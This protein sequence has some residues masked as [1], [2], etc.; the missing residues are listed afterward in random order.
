MKRMGW[1]VLDFVLAAIV[2]VLGN[3]VASYLQERFSLTDPVRFTFVA[4]LF[5]VCLG[6]LLLA[7]LKRSHLEAKDPTSRGAIR[8]EI[9][10]RVRELRGR[11]VGIEVEEMTQGTAQVSDEIDTVAEGG[12]AVGFKAKKLGGGTVKT[13]QKV[14]KVDNGGTVTGASINRLG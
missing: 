12:E 7:T 10:R 3:I 5:V 2:A 6:L 13:D 9:Q 14:D 8:V 11:L 4:I 1:I